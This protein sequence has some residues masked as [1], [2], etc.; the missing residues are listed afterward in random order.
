[1]DHHHKEQRWDQQNQRGNRRDLIV[2]R[3]AGVIEQ[4]RQ[5][6]DIR[7]PDEESAGKLI[8]RLQKNKDAGGNDPPG[9]ACGSTMCQKV[10]TGPAPRLRDA[11][12]SSGSMAENAATQI[13]TE[14]I[15]PWTLC[16]STTPAI[17]PFNPH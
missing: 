17:L 1:M 9:A 11:R 12:A 16:T 14:Y 10:Y 6:G 13:H 5:R 15:R 2:T 7:R 8:Q 3:H 4:Q